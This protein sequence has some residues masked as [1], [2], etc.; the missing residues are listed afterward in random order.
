MS[1]HLKYN[2]ALIGLPNPPTP[3]ISRLLWSQLFFYIKITMLNKQLGVNCWQT[4]QMSVCRMSSGYVGLYKELFTT[5]KKTCKLHMEWFCVLR[6]KTA[7]IRF[8][9]SEEIEGKYEHPCFPGKYFF[10]CSFY[11]DIFFFG[12]TM[13][14]KCNIHSTTCDC[15]LGAKI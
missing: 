6:G 7:L 12:S 5:V 9:Y 14:S 15:V 4:S 8:P 2:N 3:Y 10:L 1:K 11:N 13:P